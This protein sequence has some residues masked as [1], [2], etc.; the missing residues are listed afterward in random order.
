MASS[1]RRTRVAVNGFGRIGRLV[2]RLLLEQQ[3]G[4]D[5]AGFEVVLVNDMH[6]DATTHAYLLEFDSV[7]GR[8]DGFTCAA[9]PPAPS[10]QPGAVP[11]LPTFEVR[12]TN[13]IS[14]AGAGAASKTAS[15]SPRSAMILVATESDPARVPWRDLRI[16]LVVEC[17]GALRKRALLEPVLGAGVRRI[18][19]SAPMKEGVPN[20]VVGVNDAVYD[21]AA[22]PI[23]TAASC[24]TNALAPVVAVLLRELGIVHGMVTTIHN[25]TNTQ[26]TVD[27]AWPGEKEIRRTRGAG[28]NLIPT[29]TGSAKAI[30][31]IF[32]EL[33]G[34]L[35]GR[36]VRVPLAVG[37]SIVDCVFEVKRATSV[38]EVNGLLE[39]AAAPGGE[40]EGILGFETRPLVSTDYNNEARSGVVDAG[41]TM[42]TDGTL[43][44]LYVWYDNEWGCACR[45]RDLVLRA[46]AGL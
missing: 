9:H 16:D 35:D 15:S 38:A 27:T 11:Q 8:W 22:H 42:V 26:C 5:Q 45:T 13:T 21:P 25:L 44:K 1:S 18:V 30:T 46:L 4:A 41:S 33:K 7:H 28:M 19:V 31:Q 24:T 10:S 32:P 40:L 29:T 12:C 6:G 17:T 23:V 2:A 14:A 43:V 37:G 34:L 3:L 20:V 39:R 36:A